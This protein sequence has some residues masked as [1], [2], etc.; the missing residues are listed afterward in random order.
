MRDVPE[1]I[2]FQE[3]E[4]RVRRYPTSE[5]L[6]RVADAASTLDGLP[7]GLRTTGPFTNNVQPHALAAV[8][9]AAI[10]AGNDH[11]ARAVGIP[12]LE[13]LCQAFH[14]IE[15]PFTKTGS[16]PG[17]LASFM[18]RIAYEQFPFQQS[19]FE[20]LARTEALLR[21]ATRTDQ[22]VITP[23]FWHEALGCTLTEFVGVGMLLNVGALK[24]RG[25]YDPSW[26]SQ[27][28]F[29]AILARLPA[30]T[31]R[32]VSERFFLSTRVQFRTTAAEHRLH[33]PW[34]RRFEFNPLV[35]HPFIEQPDGRY[36]APVPRYALTRVTPAGLYYIGLQ[37]AGTAFTT[38]LGDVFEHY[39]GDHVALTNP[40]LMLHDIE[41]AKGKRTADWIVVLP[42]AVLVVE[43]KATPLSEGGRLG[44]AK[45]EDDLARAPGKAVT[46]IDRTVELIRQRHQA[47]AVVPTDRPIIGMIVTLQPYYQCN[48]DIVWGSS[49]RET[50]IVLASSREL[51][52]LVS[53][54]EN[55]A[56]DV[57]V[58]LVADPARAGWNLGNAI[59]SY[60]SGRNPILDEAWCAYPFG[61]AGDDS[62]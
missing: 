12:D 21:A 44:T 40:E 11:R 58:D 42:H 35:I 17:S 5:V 59:A 4:Q 2:K 48:S 18:V 46:Q 16:A 41:Y 62:A 1:V 13:M 28:N 30:S 54:S 39:V 57:L 45:L 3:F 19:M 52:H 56:D 53:L 55:S 26:L 61:A 36:I 25:Y 51:E 14:S 31:I 10:V 29:E 49:H 43:V 7:R 50:P 9:K 27:A 47:V 20:D 22:G 6:Q 60:P 32:S 33:D 24:N 38:A 8:A 37:H 15:E 23:E 34:L